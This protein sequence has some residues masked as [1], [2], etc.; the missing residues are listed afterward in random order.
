MVRPREAL[1]DPSIAFRD[2]VLQCPIIESIRR[3]IRQLRMHPVLHLQSDRLM[4]NKNQ[5]L[6]QTFV[7]PSLRSLST[8]NNG[9][10]LQVIAN[11]NGLLGRFQQRKQTLRLDCLRCFI[12][13]HVLEFEIV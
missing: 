6:E 11:K 5:P 8:D 13:E 12:D 2:S 3:E 4:P 9:S 1:I 10:Q 7:K